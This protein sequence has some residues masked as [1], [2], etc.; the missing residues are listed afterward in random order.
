MASRPTAARRSAWRAGVAV[1]VLIGIGT[2]AC[3]SG[4]D[5]GS[6][7]TTDGATTSVAPATTVATTTT[8]TAPTTTRL[9]ARP[10]G[11]GIGDAM[12]P[13]LGNGGY[14]VESYEISID[15]DT[16]DP[17]ITATTVVVA[18][19]TQDLSVFDLDLHGLTV[20]AVSIDGTAAVVAR[21]ADELIITPS[22]A[23]ARGRRFTVSVSYSGAP[24]PLPD[25]DIG[26]VGWLRSGTTTYVV[27]EPNGAHTWF[28][29][30]DHPGDKATFVFRISVPSTVTAVA[31]GVLRD[32]HTDGAR[33]IWTWD[34]REPMATYLAQVAI[35]DFTVHTAEGPHGIVVRHAF[36]TRI[37]AVAAAA[38]ARTGDRIRSRPTARS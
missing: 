9:D 3:S 37:D 16:N 25:P 31:N 1:A 8:T 17:A 21:D 30:N 27:A 15:A 19:A 12:F 23:I 11:R 6:T 10:G 14:D 29:S 2:G 5:L 26:R 7:A 18:T 36:A 4:H 22:V 34:Q 33:T 38:T 20:S 28:P 24:E 35:G 32:K 13:D